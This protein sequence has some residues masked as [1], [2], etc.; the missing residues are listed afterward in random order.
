MASIN[1]DIWGDS[2]TWEHPTLINDAVWVV[3]SDHKISDIYWG[4]VIDFGEPVDT[5]PA[6]WGWKNDCSWSTWHCRS[7]TSGAVEDAVSSNTDAIPVMGWLWGQYAGTYSYPYHEFLPHARMAYDTVIDADYDEGYAKSGLM[8]GNFY[9]SRP[10]ADMNYSGFVASPKFDF[11]K[12]DP[13]D[14]LLIFSEENPA[15]DV[16]ISNLLTIIS[17][18]WI[19]MSVNMDSMYCGDPTGTITRDGFG[20]YGAQ[21]AQMSGMGDVPMTSQLITYWTNTEDPTDMVGHRTCLPPSFSGNVAYM[22]EHIPWGDTVIRRANSTQ[23]GYGRYQQVGGH[24]KA[25]IS[26]YKTDTNVWYARFTSNIQDFAGDDGISYHWALIECDDDGNAI[27]LSATSGNAHW[28]TSLVI[29]SKPE[30]MTVEEAMKRALLHECA[31]FGTKFADTEQRASSA[32]LTSAGTG[33][34]L[35]IPVF[36]DNMH[37]TGLY[38]TGQGYLDDP[39]VDESSARDF[40]FNPA[41]DIPDDPGEDVPS[42]KSGDWSYQLNHYSIANN[43]QYFVL[44]ASKLATFTEWC[45]GTRE[46]IDP[47]DPNNHIVHSNLEW[48]GVDCTDWILCIKQYPFMIPRESTNTDIKVGWIPVKYEDAM[49]VEQNLS[50]PLYKYNTH[51]C[52]FDL[53]SQKL[54]DNFLGKNFRGTGLSKVWAL[55]PFYGFLELDL[56]RYYEMTVTFKLIVDFV[57]GVG[58]YMIFADG[59]LFDTVDCTV[60]MDLPVSGRNMGSYQNTMRQYDEQLKNARFSKFFGAAGGLISTV[61]G[62]GTGNY[63]MAGQGALST[64]QSLI[65]PTTQNVEYKLNHT[66]PDGGMC[67]TASP[68]CGLMQDLKVRIIVARPKCHTGYSADVPTYKDAYGKTMGYACLRSGTLS[69]FS[70]LTVCS[71]FRSDAISATGKERELIDQFM[72]SGVIV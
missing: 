8:L 9:L 72:S 43:N 27:D 69:S 17:A 61:I 19:P 14:G 1:T 24:A 32:D 57:M 26:I 53:G 30:D 34:G 55:L 52:E 48:N 10:W 3:D 71:G 49:Q 45:K 25:N 59:V 28:L 37:T 54:D 18:G 15:T 39:N 63:Y 67:S 60:G 44:D 31:Y 65:N 58:C 41:P 46:E 12:I 22:A 68:F 5:S 62:G 2:S 70:G 33:E 35:Y 7:T 38:K 40:D 13:N 42:G 23:F 51:D 29:D 56:G 16:P 50:A 36:T 66:L 6:F 64:I 4:G 47:D 20:M 11:Y 21:M